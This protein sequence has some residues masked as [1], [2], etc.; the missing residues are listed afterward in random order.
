MDLGPSRQPAQGADTGDL[1]PVVVPHRMSVEIFARLRPYT[2]L[3]SACVAYIRVS[4]MLVDAA[5]TDREAA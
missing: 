5:R 1:P 2:H 3:T 4:F